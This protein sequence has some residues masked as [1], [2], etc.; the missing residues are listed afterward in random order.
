[1]ARAHARLCEVLGRP[2]PLAE[3]FSHTTISSLAAR[4]AGEPEPRGTEAAKDI[5]DR[6]ASRRA[7]MDRRRARTRS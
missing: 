5:H 6:A 7:A 2:I 3:L 4:L 1:M